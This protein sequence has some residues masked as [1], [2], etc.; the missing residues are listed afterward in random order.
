[1]EPAPSATLLAAEAVLLL[2]METEF[3]PDAVA[4]PSTRQLS[5]T[6]LLSTTQLALPPISTDCARTSCAAPASPTPSVNAMAALSSELLRAPSDRR[7]SMTTPGDWLLA[8]SEAT[9]ICPSA[10][11][12][13]LR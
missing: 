11:F 1:M 10:L 9:T 2:P 7:W 8:N 12:Q 3:A 13:T 5:I 4:L 6:L